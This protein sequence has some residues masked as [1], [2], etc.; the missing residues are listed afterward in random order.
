MIPKRDIF[1]AA[2]SLALT[3]QQSWRGTLRLAWHPEFGWWYARVG[4]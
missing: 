3:I 2:R 1:A 4:Q